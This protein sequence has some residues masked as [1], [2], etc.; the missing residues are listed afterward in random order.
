MNT[1]KPKSF[2]VKHKTENIRMNSQSGGVFTAL[3]DLVL[4]DSGVIYGCVQDEHFT[5]VHTRAETAQDRDRMRG[6]K[7]VQSVVGDIFQQVKDDLDQGR[8]VLFSGTSCQ[9]DGLK[10]FLGK[11]YPNLLTV[12]LIC[13][14]VPSPLLL[15]KYLAWQQNRNKKELASF[16]FRDKDFGWSSHTET[17]TFTDGS[18]ISSLVYRTLFYSHLYI[19]PSC[20]KCPYK[21]IMHPGDITIADYLG[22][23]KAAPGFKDQKGVSLVLVNS[24]KGAAA[25]EKIKDVV[26]WCETRIEDSMQPPL[27][28]PFAAPPKRAQGMHDLISLPF[29]KVAVRYGGHGLIKSIKRKIKKIIKK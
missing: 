5:A 12:D 15:E 25:F 24:D 27:V 23:D 8:Q 14:G 3:S 9:V 29:E 4:A 18:K 22:I 16:N 11:E 1:E 20:Y 17:L 10:G 28:G 21:Q 6:S 13:H 7:Y 19:R 26:E 2:A